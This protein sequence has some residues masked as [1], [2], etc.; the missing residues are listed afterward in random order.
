MNHGKKNGR[1]EERGTDAIELA[2]LNGIE[3]YNREQAKK[4]QSGGKPSANKP[5]NKAGEKPQNTRKNLGEERSAEA[6]REAGLKPRRRSQA[7][8]RGT[9]INLSAS[10]EQPE[11][12]KPT[13]RNR[14]E[15][16]KKQA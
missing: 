12:Q 6:M 16:G 9:K 4:A 11:R 14:S 15:N 3:A 10:A 2:I 5:A 7:K 13:E 8:G 1:T